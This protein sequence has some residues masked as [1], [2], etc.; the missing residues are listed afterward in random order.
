APK[1]IIADPN[2]LR[3]NETGNAMMTVG[4]TGDLLG[5]FVAGLMSQGVELL[6][7]CYKATHLLGLGAE[8]LTQT[9]ATFRAYDLARMIPGLL[10]ENK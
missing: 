4:G 3:I 10:T 7:A 8:Q 1:D 9:Q 2:H 5:G 6:E